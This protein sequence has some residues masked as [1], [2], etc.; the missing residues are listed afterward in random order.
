[1][2]EIAVLGLVAIVA[3]VFGARVTLGGRW[4]VNPPPNGRRKKP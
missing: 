1:M 3:I 4:E 2:N